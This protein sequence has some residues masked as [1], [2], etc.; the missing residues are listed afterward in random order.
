MSHY[1]LKLE[2]T[3]DAKEKIREYTFAVLGI[4]GLWGILLGT[5]PRYVVQRD[6]NQ[7]GLADIIVSPR[8][9]MEYIFLGQGN[10]FYR[11][12]EEVQERERIEIRNEIRKKLLKK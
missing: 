9:G 5:E 4:A 7:D 10:G 2:D 3:M 8:F 1:K 6:V 11:S 12:L